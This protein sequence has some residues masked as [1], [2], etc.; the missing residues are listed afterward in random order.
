MQ[1][2]FVSGLI[3]FAD[4]AVY[5]FIYG[6]LL[7]KQ[8]KLKIKR[9]ER[10]VFPAKRMNFPAKIFR[11]SSENGFSREKN[12]FSGE[13][14]LFSREKIEFSGEFFG[15]FRE[16]FQN[17]GEKKQFSGEDERISGEDFRVSREKFHEKG[18]ANP[19]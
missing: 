14:F 7:K 10:I 2:S 6:S 4:Y 18:E 19:V 3:F 17:S 13:F 11:K 16:F 15:F 1:R 12:R 8:R 9:G 5:G